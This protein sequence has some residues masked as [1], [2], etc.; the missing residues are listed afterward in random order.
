MAPQSNNPTSAKS[1]VM[2]VDD[3]LETLGMLNTAL[4]SKGYTVLVAL[5]GAQAI[6]IASTV[7]PDVILLDALMPNMDGFETCRKIK[8]VNELRHIP[9]I[10]MT[11][12]SDTD[13][14][15]KAFDAGGVDY[16]TKPIRMDELFARLQTHIQNAQQVLSSRVALDSS[17]QHL[18]SANNAGELLWATAT[19]NRLLNDCQLLG[20][21]AAQLQNTL[22]TLYNLTDDPQ[23]LQWSSPG[24]TLSFSYL[25]RVGPNEHLVKLKEENQQD[26]EERLK[27]TLDLTKREAQVLLQLGRGGSNRDIADQLN[28]SPRTVTK[29]LEQIY[30]KLGVQNRTAAAAACTDALKPE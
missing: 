29:H 18:L 6:T 21:E 19:A 3:S 13:S 15:V 7:V 9:V 20:A 23:T 25:S 30:R 22:T 10:F 28:V 16:V 8:Q 2:I 5:E 17:G 26:D 14:V 24:K 11:G 1:V 12:L 4:E 27:Q